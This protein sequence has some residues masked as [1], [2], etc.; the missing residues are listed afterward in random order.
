MLFYLAYHRNVRIRGC[1]KGGSL[2]SALDRGA[3]IDMKVYVDT[4]DTREEDSH[5]AIFS[6][7][8]LSFDKKT[9]NSI[10][11]VGCLCLKVM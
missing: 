8:K 3:K 6:I 10:H 5:M 4:R 9:K 11:I 7:S 1:T 2:K